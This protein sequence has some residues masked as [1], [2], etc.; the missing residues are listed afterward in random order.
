MNTSCIYCVWLYS[1]DQR[2]KYHR[3]GSTI[4]FKSL[5]Y[6]YKLSTTDSS[7][8]PFQLLCCDPFL[9]GW[10]Y[11][12]KLCKLWHRYFLAGKVSDFSCSSFCNL[13][14]SWLF[15]CSTPLRYSIWLIMSNDCAFSSVRVI[16]NKL[17]N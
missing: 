3:Y 10:C 11:T 16:N 17:K 1:L 4:K 9:S 14:I 5:R 15:W 8:L 7:Q 12:C 2:S 13:A 6:Y